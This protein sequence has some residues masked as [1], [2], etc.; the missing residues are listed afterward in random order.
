VGITLSGLTSS[1]LDVQAL[2][3]DLMR[4]ESVP[5]LRLQ[6]NVKAQ[7]NEITALQDLNTRLAAL[8]K[9]AKELTS[10]DALAQFKASASSDAVTVTAR[11]AAGAGTIDL[12]VDSV[13]AAQKSVTG[14]M[15]TA[16]GTTFTI[17]DVK[18]EHT[19]FTAASSS[20]DDLVTALNNADAGVRA[21]KIAA[22][23]D[24]GTGEKLYRLQLT[25][26]E[27]GAANAFSFH[28]G[29]AADVEAGAATN[30]L[31]APGA[32][33]V[34]AAADTSV[35]L[36]VGTAAEQTVTSST[37]SLK[38]LLPGVDVTVAKAATTPVTITVAPDAEARSATVKGFVDSI[39]SILSRISALT[40]VTKNPDGTTT[41]A[42]LAGESIVRT[43][44]QTLL[45]A[46]TDPLED[47]SLSSIGI[48]ITRYGE[49]T[50]DAEKLEAALA[51][52]PDKV[53]NT[54]TQ[55]ASR[56]QGAAD[57]LSDK[58]DGLLTTSIQNRETNATR[59]DEQI[60]RWDDRLAQRYNR[61]TA[62]FTSLEVQLARLESQQKWLTGQ[63]NALNPS[64]S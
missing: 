46:A 1:G 39:S 49:I 18:G 23:T 13:A 25:A 34:T 64:K 32:A 22:G 36:W 16:P 35:R 48:E 12:V 9:S 15:T 37:T 30:L 47:V 62:Q 63:L 2:V 33:T 31:T 59:L 21:V 7:R 42:A 28:A 58:Y 50:F 24:P 11:P 61:L 29:A 26:D 54:F 45:S 55:V 20:L 57:T 10:P 41:S 17:T 38:D 51:A 44:R 40:K 3:K 19:E 52:D 43:A 14:T 27:T 8:E 56:V 6:A 53:A 60:L 4:V 5:Q